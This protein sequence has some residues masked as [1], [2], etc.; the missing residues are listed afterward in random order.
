MFSQLKNKL[1]GFVGKLIGRKEGLEAKEQNEKEEP[2]ASREEI[3]SPAAQIEEP[4][5]EIAKTQKEPGGQ[6]G[7][8]VEK[9]EMQKEIGAPKNPAAQMQKP[10]IETRKETLPQK[11]NLV[12][13]NGRDGRASKKEEAKKFSIK[14]KAVDE[15]QVP[16]VIEEKIEAIEGKGPLPGL[17]GRIGNEKIAPILAGEG[18]SI[19]GRKKEEERTAPPQK[20][21]KKQS[22]FGIVKG[23]FSKKEE[24]APAFERVEQGKKKKGEAKKDIEISSPAAQIGEEDLQ[25]LEQK[26]LD[27][28]KEMR[29]KVGLA[30]SIGG[31]FSPTISIE[32]PDVEDLLDEL[33]LSL[34]EADVGLEVSDEVKKRLEKK[35][36]GLKVKKSGMQDEINGAVREVLEQ[37]M[38]PPGAFDFNSRLGQIQRPAKILFVGPNGAGKTTTIAKFAKMLTDKGLS[39]CLAAADTFRAAAIEQLEEHAARLHV[40]IIKNKY[41][42][43]PA[44]VAFDAI[45]YARAHGIDVVLIDSAG[46][47]DTNANLIDEMKKIGRVV[48]PDLKLYVGESIGGSALIEQIRTFH[49]AIGIDGAVLTKIDC[50][51]KGGTAISLS[52]STGVPILFLGVGQQYG[53]LKPFDAKEVA[54]QILS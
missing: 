43:D 41:G 52:Y 12:L 48:S 24:A 10:Q 47:Q 28:K 22:V 32:K 38:S 17:A 1:S 16:V 50:D 13:K 4:K 3:F 54:A 46:R 18:E 53:D 42:A 21:E 39:V 11:N 27:G 9:P 45:K 49:E 44:S 15:E 5:E 6:S 35:L 26:S 19:H 23:V 20:E 14:K 36:V 31:I 2:M 29:A 7:K 8:E 34:I 25:R 51:A 37:I 30:K 33:E 40:P